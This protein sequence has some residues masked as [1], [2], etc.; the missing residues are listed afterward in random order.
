MLLEAIYHRPKMNWAYALD[1]K[2]L[3]LRLRT[4]RGDVT[5]A[6]AIVGDKFAW[7]RTKDEVNLELFASD[8]LFDYWRT[9]YRPPYKR[10]RYCFR[11]EDTTGETIYFA[12]GGFDKTEA[13]NPN[14]YFDFPYLHETEAITQPGWVKDAVFYQIFPERFANGDPSNDPKNVEPWGGKPKGDNYF[15]GDLQGVI[16]HLEHLSELGV[17]A[18]YFTPL[19]KA[20]TNHK[21][22]T[23][24]YLKVDPHF[25]T[26][27]LL[28]KLVAQ[29]HQRGIKVLLDA[30]FNHCGETFPAFVDC[31]V[32]GPESRYSDWFHVREWPLRVE[33]GIPT[34]EAFAFEAKMPKLNT[35]NQ[36]VI[37]YLLEVARYWIEEIGIDGW[38]L[39]VANE[40]DHR[41]WREFRS[42]VKEVNPEAYVLGEIWHD[43]IE[44]LQG[45]QFDAV[46]NYPF[47]NAVLDFFADRR[48]DGEQFSH[49]IG[50]LLAS[51]PQ[52]VSEAAFNMLD[53]HDTPRILTLCDGDKRVLQLAVLF[54]FTYVGVPCIYYGGEIGMTGGNDPDCRKCMEW[55]ESKQDR[56]L[57]AFY[58]S[59]IAL[60]KRCSA[61]RTGSFRFLHAKPNDTRLAYE[62]SDAADRLVVIMNAHE[63]ARSITLQLPAGQWIVEAASKG[64]RLGQ[65][66]AVDP[67]ADAVTLPLG[68]YG[69]WV[70]RQANA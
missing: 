60:R 57:F 46:M 56:K 42:V 26:N 41:F 66:L 43:S 8:E 51:Y 47:T 17:N 33:Q 67:A 25:G 24:D 34:Y 5:K 2:T 7:E 27:A 31:K 58:Q 23:Q 14:R 59:M 52:P 3:E 55:D 63:E 68:G 70:L 22:D 61:L 65:M 10:M 4:A 20:M 40:V 37:S 30:V 45:D 38:R 53:S 13:N 48:L 54:Q 9:A 35:Q 62:R 36:E 1:A 44:W 50:G 11:L 49:A 69:Y 39:D 29:C 28:K 21:Y 6:A 16:D 64:E 15:G 18:I 19:F 12:E 32:N